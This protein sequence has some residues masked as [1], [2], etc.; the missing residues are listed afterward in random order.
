[1]RR[2]KVLWLPEKHIDPMWHE[3]IM[4]LIGRAHDLALL[5]EGQPLA[6]Q[7]AGV[8]VVL[9]SG[10]SVGTHA[11]MDVAVNCQLWQILGTGLDHVD[12][13][14]IRGRGMLAAN[15]PGTSSGAALG[16][17]AMMM[18]LMLARRYHEASAVF[19]ARGFGQPLGHTLAGATLGLIGFGASGQELARRAKPF[20]MRILGI[21][22]RQIEPEIVREIGP[23]FLGTPADL[24]RVIAES[25]YLSLHLHLND[26]TRHIL[27]ARRIGLMKPTACLINVARG[28]LADEAALYTALLQGR[29]G[30]AGLD[31]F[32]EEPPDPA[33]PVF[34]L[35]NV[36]ALP[37]VAGG[38]DGTIQNRVAMA[39]ENVN[40]IA[41][42]LAPLYQVG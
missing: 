28:A 40:R 36:V 39:A 13:P 1:M 8:E 25:D 21:D 16:E 22:V 2:I 32:S 18:I 19:R 37:H 33:R 9:D 24:D 5:D 17:C 3:Q 14:Y 20:G 26:Q 4:A 30:G 23:D 29:L 31:V 12:L 7:F 42:G 27:D 34:Q 6:P 11:M 15:C 35:P 10:G 41:Q 38:T